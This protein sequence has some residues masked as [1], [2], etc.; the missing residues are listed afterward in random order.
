[1]N[2]LPA[3]EEVTQ[4]LHLSIPLTAA[5]QLE[6][7]EFSIT[8]VRIAAPLAPNR[9]HHQTAFGG[10]Q[11]MVGV[12]SGWTQAHAL[13][14]QSGMPATLVVQHSAMDFHAPARGDFEALSSLLDSEAQTFVETLRQGRRARIEIHTEIRQAGRRVSGHVGRYVAVPEEQAA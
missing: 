3:A 1:M 6:V 2:A 12:V 11:A 10:S 8:R 7:V 4:F 13:V 14:L 5:A 9:N